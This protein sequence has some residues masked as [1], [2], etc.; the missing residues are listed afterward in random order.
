MRVIFK[1]T[2]TA[3]TS[4]LKKYLDEKLVCS[5]EKIIRDDALLEIEFER[6]TQHHQKG[7]VWRAEANLTFG[8]RLIRAE[9][10]GEDP[11]EAIDLLEDEL[12]REV[13]TF[14]NKKATE[15]RKGARD[16]KR[17]IRQEGF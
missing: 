17:K 11:R 4:A 10:S 8:K 14:K 7:K 13:K 12:I 15:S 5:L 2:K 16:I 3:L 9:A 1:R 6:T